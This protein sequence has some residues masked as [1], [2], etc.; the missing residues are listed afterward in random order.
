MIRRIGPIL[1]FVALVALAVPATGGES[2]TEASGACPFSERAVAKDA[3]AVAPLTGGNDKAGAGCPWSGGDRAETN[4]GC[5]FS[6]KTED[7]ATGCPYS[8]KGN[9]VASGCPFSDKGDDVARGCPF[10]GEER[11]QARTP[12]GGC[13]YLAE[14]TAPIDRG[15]VRS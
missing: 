4:G 5:P 7:V 6:G 15:R 14:D 2:A 1:M 9:D 11:A 13:P 12:R 8:G 3:E 10:S